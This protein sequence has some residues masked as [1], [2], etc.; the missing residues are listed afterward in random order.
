M[1]D[2]EKYNPSCT[3]NFETIRGDFQYVKEKK[4]IEAPYRL[5]LSFCLDLSFFFFFYYSALFSQLG[6]DSER[7][8]CW[9]FFAQQHLTI[10]LTLTPAAVLQGQHGT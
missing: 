5:I 9:W 6:F 7:N 4:I 1:F 10:K 8:L 2:S 3:V